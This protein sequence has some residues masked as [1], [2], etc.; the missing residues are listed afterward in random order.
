MSKQ[1]VQ[2]IPRDDT[3]AP[4]GNRYDFPM[5]A[6]INRI[7]PGLMVALC[8]LIVV[9]ASLQSEDGGSG[10]GRFLRLALVIVLYV[11][12]IFPITILSVRKTAQ[13]VG[14]SLPRAI[15]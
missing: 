2:Q 8:V 13:A 1:R 14:V 11:A 6:T 4:L 12:V 9:I 3:D 15:A 7:L 10:W 5:S